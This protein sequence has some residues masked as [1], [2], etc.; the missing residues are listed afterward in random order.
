MTAVAQTSLDAYRTFS[1]PDLQKKE[2][3]VLD[4]F[5]ANPGAEVT[6]EELAE[7]MRWKES[8]VCGRTFSLVAKKCLEEIDG[9]KT[10]SGRAAKLLRVPVVG[11][12]ALFQ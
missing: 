9:G 6:R 2:R 11:Q 8:A 1:A 7:N 3:E 4:W 10:S 5:A 12:K